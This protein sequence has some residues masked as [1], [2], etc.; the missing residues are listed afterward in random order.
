MPL[1]E[2]NKVGDLP[3]GVHE[4]SLAEVVARFGGGSVQRQAVTARLTRIHE[5]ALRSGAADRLMVFGSYVT[6]KPDPNDI[7]VVLVMRDSFALR[8][9][10]AESLA[11]FDHLRASAEL[12]A[13]IFWVRP[14]MLIVETLDQFIASWQVKRDRTRRGIVEIRV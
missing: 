7:D 5:L 2:F 4:A 3:P 11:L 8:Q 1:P 14:G 6:D 13:S 12:G 10:P 9:C